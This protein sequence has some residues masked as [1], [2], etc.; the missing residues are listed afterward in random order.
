MK[1]WWWSRLG[2]PKPSSPGPFPG[3][4]GLSVAGL[5]FATREAGSSQTVPAFQVPQMPNN[6]LPGLYWFQSRIWGSSQWVVELI[7]AN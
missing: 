5:E 1:L 4:A 2:T 3:W 6:M 7:T